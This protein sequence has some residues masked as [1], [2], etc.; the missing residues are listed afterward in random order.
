MKSILKDADLP[1]SPSSEVTTGGNAAGDDESAA[2]PAAASSELLQKESQLSTELSS[3]RSS[4]AAIDRSNHSAFSLV[5]SSQ[6]ALDLARELTKASVTDP[7]LL[8]SGQCSCIV[9]NYINAG[10]ILLPFGKPPLSVF[11]TASIA[12]IAPPSHFACCI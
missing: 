7:S 9:V 11:T 2:L 3:R 8:G 10:Y 6:G 5:R 4:S 1:S 12:S